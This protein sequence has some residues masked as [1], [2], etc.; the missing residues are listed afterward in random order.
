MK[1]PAPSGPRARRRPGRFGGLAVRLAIAFAVVAVATAVAVAIAAPPI[2]GRGFAMMQATG[3]A[4]GPGAGMGAG[5]GAGG[6][7][8]GGGLGQGGGQ[9]PGGGAGT[10]A[11]GTGTPG[12]YLA[13][14]QAET[15]QT[16]MLVALVAAA[17]ASLLGIV[18]ARHLARPLER[19]EEAA[20]AVAQGDLGARSGIA[21]RGDEFGSLGRSFDAMAADL[22]RGEAARR[23]FFQDAAHEMKT[24]LA[25]IDATAA[26]VMDGV[27]EHDDRHLATIREQARLLRRVV[28]DLRTI[29]LADAGALALRLAPVPADDVVEAV[30]DSFAARAAAA[31]IELVVAPGAGGSPVVLVDRDRLAQA[32]ATMVDNALRFAPAG[33]H[34]LVGRVQGGEGMIRFQVADDGPG[35]PPD[36]L[37]H[38]FDRLYQADAGRD[39]GTGTSGLGLAI[40]RAIA[41]AH[42]GGVGAENRPEG[43]VAFWLEV[44]AKA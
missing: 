12:A 22:E 39:R 4:G 31:R 32:L 26:A 5:H 41:D 24:P 40:A 36:D 16:I 8:Q 2:V 23:R 25:V 20:A 35:V 29:S 37:P 14:A 17:V 34:V 3:S 43:G 19:L 10:S 44:P 33:G 7:G 6:Q 28:D 38:V 21:G 11:S 9:G 30:A 1:M 27:Y 18:I 42:G 13:Q 15:T